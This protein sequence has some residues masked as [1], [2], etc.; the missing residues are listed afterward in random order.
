MPLT[1]TA[2]R[3]ARPK[4]KVYKLRDERGLLLLVRPTGAKWWRLRYK[5]QGKENMLSLGVYPADV[6]LSMARERR[7]AARRLIADGQDPSAERGAEKQSLKLASGATFEKIARH[8]LATPPARSA[9]AR[10]RSRPIRK[11]SG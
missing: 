10:A 11:R 7:D 3:Q 6:S 5:I 9:A 4:E 1:D 2:V 8:Y